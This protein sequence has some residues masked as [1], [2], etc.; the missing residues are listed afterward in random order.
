M[1]VL[2]ISS[3]SDQEDELYRI[4]GARIKLIRVQRGLSQNQLA[5]AVGLSR[6]SMS[7]V[8]NGRQRL[9]AHNLVAI[10]QALA[11]DPAIFLGQEDLPQFTAQLPYPTDRL[12][13]FLEMASEEIGGFLQALKGE[14]PMPGERGESRR[15]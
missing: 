5:A 9:L 8:E 13:V 2:S 1:T 7:N 15:D 6:A 11:V 12:R 14:A 10:G 3:A 4:L